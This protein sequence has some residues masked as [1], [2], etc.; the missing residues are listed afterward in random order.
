MAAE[1]QCDR[2]MSDM[3]VQMKQNGVSEV[4]EFLHAKKKK[5]KK[6]TKKGH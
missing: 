5:K 4:T 6:Q 2:M 1:R 3:E